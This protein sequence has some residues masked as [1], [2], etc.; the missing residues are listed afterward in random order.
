MLREIHPAGRH[1]SVNNSWLLTLTC[2][3][4]GWILRNVVNFL[5]FYQLIKDM[6]PK[7]FG[8]LVL[9]NFFSSSYPK[10]YLLDTP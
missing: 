3:P 1:V 7:I 4:V 8:N 9:L 5:V 6:C 10:I 2:L